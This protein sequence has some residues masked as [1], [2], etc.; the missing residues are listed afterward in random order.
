MKRVLTLAALLAL[1][2]CATSTPAPA[3]EP[4]APV[5]QV[6]PTEDQCGAGALQ[7]LVGRPKVEIPIP[8]NPN[9]RRVVCTTCPMTR[10]YRAERQT[11]MFDAATGL[12][13]SVACN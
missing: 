2:A 12:V 5:S 7:Y 11:I 3:P 10:D 1:S 4:A 6:R 9:N 8:A 13:T